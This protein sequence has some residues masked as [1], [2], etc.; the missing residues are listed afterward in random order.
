MSGQANYPTALDDDASLYDVTNNVTAIDAAHHNN[1]KEAVKAIER[2]I[3]VIGSASPTALDY[4][5]SNHTHDGA[6]GSGQRVNPTT[7]L[8]PSGGFPSGGQ[9]YDHLMNATLH[10]PSALLATGIA[11]MLAPALVRVPSQAILRATGLASVVSQ[12]DATILI[13]VPSQIGR[14]LANMI[15]LGSI[16]SGLN[17]GIPISFGLTMRVENIRANLKMGPTA[18]TIVANVRFG[19]TSLWQASLG[20]RPMFAPVGATNYG[21]AS[22]NLV[23][24]PSGAI[25][26]LDIDEAVD[27]ELA[28]DLSINLVFRD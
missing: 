1:I 28:S 25:I 26:Q 13:S 8:I 11:T 21:H 20:N 23:T 9:L 3:G 5:L 10:N 18:A 27:P 12:S 24:Y 2:R 15:L 22:P 7:I 19:P 17:R 4:Q 16:P 6:S 14:F